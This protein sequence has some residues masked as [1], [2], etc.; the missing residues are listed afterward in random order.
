MSDLSI[1]HGNLVSWLRTKVDGL[2]E[3]KPSASD[4]KEYAQIL[5][6]LK[7][8]KPH[9]AGPAVSFDGDKTLDELLKE[10]GLA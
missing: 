5:K 10:K 1:I 6:L 7:D 8:S 9:G 3:D 4:V 2:V